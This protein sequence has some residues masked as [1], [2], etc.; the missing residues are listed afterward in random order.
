MKRTSFKHNALIVITLGLVV[1]L[2]ICCINTVQ[3]KNNNRREVIVSSHCSSEETTS[4][5]LFSI[6]QVKKQLAKKHIAIKIDKQRN[7]CGYLFINGSKRKAITSALTDMDLL[8][9]V[10]KFFSN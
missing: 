1:L 7:L 2:S 4:D 3:P 9:E 6:D 8:Q 10:N 5:I